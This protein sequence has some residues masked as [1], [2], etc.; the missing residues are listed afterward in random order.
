MVN[1]LLLAG[2]ERR[3]DIYKS[4]LCNDDGKTALQT[5]FVIRNYAAAIKSWIIVQWAGVFF[6]ASMKGPQKREVDL[7]TG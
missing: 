7:M 6:G 3:W 1:Q 4:Y 5:K 2:F